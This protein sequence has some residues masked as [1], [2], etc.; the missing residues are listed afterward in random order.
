[1][2]FKAGVDALFRVIPLRD[3]ARDGFAPARDMS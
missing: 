1:M 3:E 2:P